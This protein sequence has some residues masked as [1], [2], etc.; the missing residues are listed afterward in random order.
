[1]QHARDRAGRAQFGAPKSEVER[2]KIVVRIDQIGLDNRV[3]EGGDW[4]GGG[5]DRRERFDVRDVA[6]AKIE[7]L[8]ERERPG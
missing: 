2:P 6:R 7:N 8:G 1:M 4:P 3:F 5:W